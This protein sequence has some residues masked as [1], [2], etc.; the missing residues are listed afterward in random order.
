MKPLIFLLL[1][2]P[3]TAIGQG[4]IFSLKGGPTAGFQRWDNSFQSRSFLFRYHAVLAAETYTEEDKF[5]L[6]AQAGYHIKGSAI[7]TFPSVVQTPVGPR[8]YP[9]FSIPFEFRNA[10]LTI[11]A[12]QKFERSESSKLYYL[13][14]IRGDYTVSTQL[15]PDNLDEFSLYSTIYPFDG[16]VNKI[17]A[18]ATIGGGLEFLFSEYVGGL[19]EFT[20]NPDFTKQY[21]QPAIP[22][23]RNPNGD[24]TT[25]TIPKRQ[26]TN[27]TLELTLG[28]RFIRKI[29]Y[30]D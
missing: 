30:L 14:G 1:L 6:F 17:N 26:I 8:Q 21:N 12:K 5:S 27:L 19:L 29:E 7:R 24:N 11:G 15:R 9:G 16:F 4:T 28:V 3:A 2:A 10:S 25:I 20:I 23:I 22:N 18:G 13:F